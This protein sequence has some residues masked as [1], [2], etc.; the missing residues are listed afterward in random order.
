[1]LR[2]SQIDT[3]RTI[4]G[5]IVSVELKAEK[6]DIQRQSQIDRKI[7][8]KLESVERRIE[9]ADIHLTEKLLAPPMISL[10]PLQCLM[11][12]TIPKR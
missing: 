3:D 5:K 9:R 2:Q 10:H 4:D 1:M 6:A 8:G 12:D 7:D 11:I